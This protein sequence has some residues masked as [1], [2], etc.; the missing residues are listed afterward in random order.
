M[1]DARRLQ[2]YNTIVTVVFYLES[3]GRPHS[4]S[5]GSK[6]VKTENDIASGGIPNSRCIKLRGVVRGPPKSAV[7]KNTFSFLS[8]YYY[9][10][11]AGARLVRS[12]TYDV[13]RIFLLFVLLHPSAALNVLGFK[14]YPTCVCVL[15][16]AYDKCVL[17]KAEAR[18]RNDSNNNTIIFDVWTFLNPAPLT[19][20][21]IPN[22]KSE[23][24]HYILYYVREKI[25]LSVYF[26]LMR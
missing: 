24:T 13:S 17:H 5:T 20:L 12:I 14:R 1:P 21:G 4:G 18:F 7:D 2:T 8:Y 16:R 10:I 25:P 23:T 26:G 22:R 15:W 19:H 3:S 6:L 9:C 11:T